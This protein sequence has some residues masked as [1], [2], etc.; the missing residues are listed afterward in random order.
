[1]PTRYALELEGLKGAVS[2]ETFKEPT[3]RQEAKKTV[4]K[5]FEERYQG[6]KNRWF[7]TPLRVRPALAHLG[8]FSRLSSA[9][10][11]SYSFERRVGIVLLIE[12]AHH[13]FSSIEG[14]WDALPRL[15]HCIPP[16][17]VD[18][19]LMW[20]CRHA[21]CPR[22]R[23]LDSSRGPGGPKFESLPRAQALSLTLA[24]CT[25]S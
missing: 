2:N 9:I 8:C 20:S 15:Q 1:M 24:L 14:N 21:P 5:L 3:Q 13:G 6:G 23:V 7:F 22:A 19:I 10:P 11:W 18:F 16:L 4:K 25:Q 12:A 17:I